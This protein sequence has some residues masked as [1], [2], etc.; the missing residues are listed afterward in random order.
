M[1]PS[2][3]QSVTGRVS[4]VSA[5]RY[6][7]LSP[8]PVPKLASHGLRL[9]RRDPPTR[10]SHDRRGFKPTAGDN[11]VAV[12]HEFETPEAARAFFE[13]EELQGAMERGGVDRASLQLHLFERD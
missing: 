11:L 3:N 4:L 13:N 7:D 6:A 1:W 8:K 10:G 9:G 5:L 2:Q 12:T